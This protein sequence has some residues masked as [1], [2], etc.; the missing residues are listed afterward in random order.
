[1]IQKKIEEKSALQKTLKDNELNKI[2]AMEQL[3]KER[4]DDVRAA[5]EYG[6]ILEKQ[7]NERIEYFKKIERSSNNFMSKMVDTVLKD[8]NE[9]NNEEEEK[10]RQYLAEKEIR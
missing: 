8:M 3:K 10:M 7:E 5:E 2:K 1:M 4:E 6:K 9:K